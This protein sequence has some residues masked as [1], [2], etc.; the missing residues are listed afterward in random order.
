[1]KTPDYIRTVESVTP[2][3]SLVRFQDGSH[4]VI[5]YDPADRTISLQWQPGDILRISPPVQYGC[6]RE[7][8]RHQEPP[9][10]GW[11]YQDSYLL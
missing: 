2:N 3:G 5:H 6:L 9:G 4:A 11:L 10:H 1:M 8:Q 7:F